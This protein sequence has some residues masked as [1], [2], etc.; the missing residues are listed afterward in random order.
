MGSGTTVKPGF[1]GSF[2]FSKEKQDS[3]LTGRNSKKILYLFGCTPT[4]IFGFG[5]PGN[6]DGVRKGYAVLFKQ[7]GFN[8][9]TAEMD[10]VRKICPDDIALIEIRI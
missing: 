10:G 3:Y 7:G 4:F 8:L 2:S 5:Q 1:H 9:R 6:L